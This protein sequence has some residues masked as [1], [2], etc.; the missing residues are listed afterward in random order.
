MNILLNIELM[1]LKI[2]WKLIYL[3]LNST[4]GYKM[5]SKEEL[6]EFVDSKL[7][8]VS[9]Q[10]DRFIQLISEDR[11]DEINSILLKFAETDGTDEFIQKRKWR[12]YKLKLILDNPSEDCLQG[13]LELIEFWYQNN[14]TN[15]CPQVFPSA[16]GILPVKTYFTPQ[17][18][19]SMMNK[20]QAWLIQ[21]IEK[22][23]IEESSYSFY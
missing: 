2:T 16:E 22:I 1:G 6:L 21:E 19:A 7:T 12:A 11:N 9:R 13:L 5:L 20:N 14:I 4:E 23:S 10:T 15:D 8:V 3:G 17:M 18:Y